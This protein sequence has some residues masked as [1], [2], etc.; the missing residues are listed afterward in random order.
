MTDTQQSA[1]PAHAD[2]G[3]DQTGTP[4]ATPDEPTT[5]D[6]DY[7]KK[8][9]DE[10][11]KYRT[12]AKTNAQAAQKLADLEEANK[13]EA[14]KLSDRLAAAE[15][16]TTKAQTDALRYRIATKFKLSDD[17]ADLYLTG[18]DEEHLTRQA[19]GLVA[20]QQPG[21]PRPDPSQGSRGSSPAG[22]DMN[23]L[24]RRNLR[25]G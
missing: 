5:F 25:G 23:T 6:A 7:V 9:R 11:A 17:Q 14:Q 24:I 3:T 19:E 4:G 21:T 2:G 22:G 16:A 1:A 18:T 10:A 20:M 12:E 15:Q 8:L 13:T